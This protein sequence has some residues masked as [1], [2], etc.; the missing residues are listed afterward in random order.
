[1]NTLETFY[2]SRLP[3]YTPIGG[4]FFVTFRIHNALPLSVMQALQW[5]YQREIERIRKTS[6]GAQARRALIAKAR[7]AYFKQYDDRLDN[8]KSD[9]C[10]FSDPALCA[11]LAD[12]L[13]TFDDDLYEL[14]AYC[15]MPN[16]AH[17]LLSLGNQLA[18]HHHFLLDEDELVSSYQP[19]HRI[20]QRVKGASARFLNQELGRTGT[21]WQKDSYDHYVRNAKAYENILYYILRNPEKAGLVG[22]WRNYRFTYHA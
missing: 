21:F 13:H 16:H 5:E 2:K 17:L 9:R 20:M 11:S 4:T 6:L 1:M 22:D 15:I 18:D 19:L 12:H 14:K 7:Y 8:R 10:F 3:H